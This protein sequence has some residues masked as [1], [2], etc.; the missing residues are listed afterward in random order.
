MLE[1]RAKATGQVL[2]GQ[3]HFPELTAVGEQS[4]QMFASLPNGGSESMQMMRLITVTS[5]MRSI[6]LR[7][8]YFV[9]DSITRRAL[10]SAVE[11]GVKV[12]II[13]PGIYTDEATVRLA[14]LSTAAR[15]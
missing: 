8:A 3:K 6:D 9:P 4:A 13:L 15:A 12:R 5:A 11:R 10:L 7:S 14:G 2:H 1:N